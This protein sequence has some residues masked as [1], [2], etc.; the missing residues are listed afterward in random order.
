MAKTM[1]LMTKAPP[2]QD[3][4]ANGMTRMKNSELTALLF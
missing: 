1:T 3:K 2:E 4:K